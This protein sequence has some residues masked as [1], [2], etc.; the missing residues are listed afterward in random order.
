[1]KLTAI[2]ILI[3][4][5]AFSFIFH[6]IIE[7]VDSKGYGYIDRNGKVVIEPQ[8]DFAFPFSNG[9]AKVF[10]GTLGKYGLPEEGGYGFIDTTGQEVIP[11]VYEYATEFSELGT[12][13]VCKNGKYGVV[14]AQGKILIDLK[15]DYVSC[16]DSLNT[17]LCFYGELK[18]GVG[19]K[20]T[21]HIL[22]DKGE[23][24]FRLS[25]DALYVYGGYYKARNGQKYALIAPDGTALTEYRYEAL[26]DGDAELLTFQMNEKYGYLDRRG[27]EVI[28]AKF[29]EAGAFVDGKAVVKRNGKYMLIDSSGNVLVQYTADYVGTSMVAGGFTHAFEGTLS[30]YGS[31][32]NGRYYLMR[33]D[34]TYVSRGYERRDDGGTC[35]FV[36]SN[37]TWRVYENGRW[38]IL[39]MEGTELAGIECDDIYK[40]GEDRLV[41][42]KDGRYALADFQGKQITEYVFD[43]MSSTPED[44][45]CVYDAGNK[46]GLSFVR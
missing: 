12:V 37:G 44:L 21:Y 9:R 33:M 18:Y 46:P 5:V 30:T 4:R 38:Y 17:Y 26:K 6:E 39:N 27:N 24:L 45:I 23:E 7:V 36:D 41:L 19:G 15:Y 20:G 43:G 22:N 2:L 31:P 42:R 40:C 25:A 16:H 3:V 8:F 28:E 1:M 29:D 13:C 11:A 35:H 34:G 14:D 32:N 10:T